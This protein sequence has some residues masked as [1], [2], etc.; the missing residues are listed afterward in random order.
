MTYRERET[1]RESERHGEIER[2]REKERQRDRERAR[3]SA[4]ESAWERLWERDIEY[5]KGRK[6]DKKERK[7]KRDWR[8]TISNS[9]REKKEKVGYNFNKSHIITF[10][11]TLF[12]LFTL[13]TPSEGESNIGVQTVT[14]CDSPYVGDKK[15]LIQNMIIILYYQGRKRPLDTPVRKI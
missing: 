9:S 1:V 12:I 2:K 14:H 3:E 8:K 4:W 13:S 7:R 6:K 5:E 15:G 11:T 10:C